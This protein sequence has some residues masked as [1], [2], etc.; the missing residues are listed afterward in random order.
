MNDPDKKTMKYSQ[1]EI[2]EMIRKR[3]GY[4][5]NFKIENLKIDAEGNYEL[6]FVMVDEEI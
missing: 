5:E 3:D 6:N 2:L 1:S 4:D